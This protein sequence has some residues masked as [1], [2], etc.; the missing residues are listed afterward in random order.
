MWRD[1]RASHW[2]CPRRK[3]ASVPTHIMQ[4]CLLFVA[5]AWMP[6]AFSHGKYN[7]DGRNVYG[8]ARQEQGAVI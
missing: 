3:P 2:F 8:G 5:F 4:I 6:A 7:K 1:G